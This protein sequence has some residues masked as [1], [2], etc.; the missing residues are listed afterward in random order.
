MSITRRLGACGA[1]AGPMA[2]RGRA[3][4]RENRPNPRR[5]RATASPAAVAL[6]ALV[7]V[8][9]P[10]AARAQPAA[11]SAH[12]I[13]F[14][15]GVR[16]GREPDR[17]PARRLRGHGSRRVR[18]AD[19][20]PDRRVDRRPE[21]QPE[22][23]GSTPYSDRSATRGSSSVRRRAGSISISASSPPTPPTTRPRTPTGST[24]RA[25]RAQP[26][27]WATSPGPRACSASG[28]SRSTRSSTAGRRAGPGT[29]RATRTPR[30]RS[31]PRPSS[32]A[33]RR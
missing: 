31:A 30:P 22:G 33:A 21:R 16:P 7:L 15:T 6:A 29:T 17:R 4:P 20:V 8:A 19:E 23:R 27:R 1:D 18:D 2:G 3:H 9:L 26:R 10:G 14:W 32:A 28:E 11:N 25:G 13:T 5:R 24:T 12:E